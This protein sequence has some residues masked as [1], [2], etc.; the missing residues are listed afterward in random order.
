M[1]GFELLSLNSRLPYV[2]CVQYLD[3]PALTHRRMKGGII[4]VYEIMQKIENCLQN[5]LKWIKM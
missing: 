3:L 1:K 2:T 5:F 4:Q